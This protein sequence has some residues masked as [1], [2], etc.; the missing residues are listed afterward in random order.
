MLQ[1][2]GAA[3]EDLL[4]INKTIAEIKKQVK[5]QRLKAT[6]LKNS[7]DNLKEETISIDEK[8]DSLSAKISH[9]YNAKEIIT[10]F[11]KEEQER[12][13]NE[14]KFI[15]VH[16]ESSNKKNDSIQQLIELY[17]S[18]NT[19]FEAKITNEEKLKALGNKFQNN[20]SAK[21]ASEK[22]VFKTVDNE[23]MKNSAF[24]MIASI[25]VILIVFYLLDKKRKSKKKLKLL[26]KLEKN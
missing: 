1:N 20:D 12:L 18:N 23:K 8:I 5:D 19:N 3:P 17:T 16:L 15:D 6:A 4:P 24:I 25:G 13:F 21:N 9:H 11:L 10:E 2:K 7:I 14:L 26:A 22:R